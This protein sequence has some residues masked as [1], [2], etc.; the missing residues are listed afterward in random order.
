[1]NVGRSRQSVETATRTYTVGLLHVICMPSLPTCITEGNFRDSTKYIVSSS[2]FIHVAHMHMHAHQQL[3]SC[4]AFPMVTLAWLS[5][6]LAYIALPRNV[7]RARLVHQYVRGCE[8]D[9]VQ[10]DVGSRE[11]T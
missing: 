6:E 5:R 9:K 11:A 3:S 8:A 10:S 7:W 2:S 1:M 4:I